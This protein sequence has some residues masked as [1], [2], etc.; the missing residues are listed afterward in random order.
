MADAL[1]VPPAPVPPPAIPPVQP[2]I[3]P[4]QP[5]PVQPIQA[6]HVPQLN[7]SHFKPKFAG[8]PDED[9]EV[10]L[11]RT[12]DWMD[13]HISRRCQSPKFWFNI[14]RRSKIMV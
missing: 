11:L 9:A 6:A 3:P 10:H 1:P 13:T 5:I 2:T 7:W 8:K 12:N 14:S 4:A